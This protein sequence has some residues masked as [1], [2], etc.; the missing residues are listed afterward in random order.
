M[1][2]RTV[3]LSSNE[4]LITKGLR[5]SLFNLFK[6]MDG[7]NETLVSKGLRREGHAALATDRVFE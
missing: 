3:G 5:H 1:M 4:T 7:S 2:R 6:E